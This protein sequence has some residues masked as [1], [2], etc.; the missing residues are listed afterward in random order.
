M[1]RIASLR[2]SLAD[3]F[4]LEVVCFIKMIDQEYNF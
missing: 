1:I 4:L 3:F 2:F